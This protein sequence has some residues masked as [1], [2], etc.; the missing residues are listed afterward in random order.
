MIFDS[1]NES[2]ARGELMLVDGGMCHW[3]LRRD[4]QI[5]IREIISTRRGAGSMMIRRLEHIPG[6]SSI[7]AK[8]PADLPS[9][10][11]YSRRGFTLIA[12][13]ETRSG[14]TLNHWR[15]KLRRQQPPNI[16]GK[17]H[18]IYC[19]NGN[20]S[21]ADAAI[22][23]G[24]LYGAQ[25]P[26]TIY[27][28][29]Y[30]I[31]QDWKKPDRKKYM[32]ALATHQPYMATVLDWERPD[33]LPEVLDWASEATEYVDE[34]IIIPKVPGMVDRVPGTVAGKPVRL[35]YSV[36]SGYGKTLVQF[37]EF[38]DRP[39]HLL[40]GSPSRQFEAYRYLNVVSADMNYHQ[41]IATRRPVMFWAGDSHSVK[42]KSRQC[43]TLREAG[44]YIKHD[45][46]LTALKL[47]LANIKNAWESVAARAEKQ[48]APLQEAF[49]Q[50]LVNYV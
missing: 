2:A 37:A 43:P 41:R 12:T 47:S 9:N 48:Q 16:A 13:S 14:K 17:I 46:P 7:F 44:I 11:W 4:G 33:Q 38:E 39:V 40:G 25:S 19:A 24:W 18:L 50:F 1:L 35:G 8:C 29:P 20:P 32:E 22:D 15:L 28:Q 10:D 49:P 34:I 3:H 23:A 31:D 36:P 21:F 42:G 26:G 27:R 30:F 6:A 5:T 45:A